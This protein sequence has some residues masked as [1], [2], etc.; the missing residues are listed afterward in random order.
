MI[1]ALV[2][3]PVAD[4]DGV[5]FP[6]DVLIELRRRFVDL[7]GGLTIEHEVRGIWIALDGREFAEPMSPYVVA[8]S[9]WWQLPGFLAIVEWARATLRQQSMFVKIATIPEI[10]PS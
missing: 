7:A 4:N 1:E 2:L 9:S 5:R 6:D 3:I 8:V 10:W